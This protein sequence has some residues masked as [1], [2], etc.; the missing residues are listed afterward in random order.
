MPTRQPSPSPHPLAAG[1]PLPVRAEILDAHVA[2]WTR[3]AE[4]GTWL[5]GAQR[6]AVAAETR[7]ARACAL[8]QRR[9]HASSPYAVDGPHDASPAGTAALDQARIDAIHRVVTD[10][11]RLSDRLVR[12]LAAAG[13]DDAAWVEILAVVVKTICVDHFCRAIGME[14]HPLPEPLAPALFRLA[15]KLGRRSS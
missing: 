9:K 12:E 2:F 8:C 15:G 11:G 13:T 1:T 3:L 14:P 6:V 7:A 5:T 10:P 4:P